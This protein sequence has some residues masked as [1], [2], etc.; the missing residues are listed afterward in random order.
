MT[1]FQV[2]CMYSTLKN[3]WVGRSSFKLPLILFNNL[4]KTNAQ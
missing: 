2:G 3:N 1:A 4:N